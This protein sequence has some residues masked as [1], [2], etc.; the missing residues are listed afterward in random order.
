MLWR[1]SPWAKEADYYGY[2][3]SLW[4][5]VVFCILCAVVI[6]FRI[7]EKQN[8]YQ[9]VEDIANQFVLYLLFGV[10]AV[11]S[12]AILCGASGILLY[13]LGAAAIGTDVFAAVLSVDTHN[14][15]DSVKPKLLPAKGGEEK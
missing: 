2:P 14:V 3:D 13:L 8:R 6:V 5:Y 9:A 15:L 12:I 11:I 4:V 7:L 1:V 10:C